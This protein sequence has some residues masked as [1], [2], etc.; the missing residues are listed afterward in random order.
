M[1][2]IPRVLARSAA[3]LAL[4]GASA[5]YAAQASPAAQVKPLTFVST[6]AAA[7]SPPPASAPGFARAAS[8]AWVKTASM[9]R[10]SAPVRAASAG[11]PAVPCSA[12]AAACVDLSRQVAWFLRNGASMRGPVLIATGR[13]GYG[14]KV[15]T[16]RVYRKNR[17]WYSTI[18]HNAPMP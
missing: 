12:A 11:A 10:N 2:R 5:G 18:Y 1:R 3:T 14:T 13:S 4:A 17:M 7:A 9:P 16:F 6:S 15:G 8:A